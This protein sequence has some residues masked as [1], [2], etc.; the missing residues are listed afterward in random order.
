MADIKLDDDDDE[1]ND[2][3]LVQQT[4]SDPKEISN[5]AIPTPPP[6]KLSIP[7]HSSVMNTLESEMNT[8]DLNDSKFDKDEQSSGKETDNNLKKEPTTA[9][10]P[11][12]TLP[13]ESC[14]AKLP[15]P[16]ETTKTSQQ[17]AII[18]PSQI[19]ITI[20]E[21]QKIGEGMGSYVVYTV[22]TR[23][24]LPYFRRQSMT[25]NRRFSDFLG[26]HSKLLMKHAQSGR[27]I[28][29]PPAKS[30]VGTAKVK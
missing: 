25:V 20:S 21:P 16:S 28:P 22:N 7:Q 24:T 3:T 4:D 2:K 10:K 30:A 27:I 8:I 29:P 9:E 6:R 5:G 23:T 15:Q 18:T 11:L 12:E 26:L 17:P 1:D 14:Q 19:T 13:I